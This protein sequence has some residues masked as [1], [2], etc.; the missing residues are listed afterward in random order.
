MVNPGICPFTHY[1]LD[2]SFG[3]SVCLWRVG[4]GSN[5][6]KTKALTGSLE[7]EGFVAGSVV[8]HDALD[9]DA[10]ALVIGD[11]G[12]EESDGAAAGLVGLDLGKGG[13]RMVV[14][15]DMHMVPADAAILCLPDTMA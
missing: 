4:P 15:G 5:V 13:A 1:G 12:F 14:Y 9:L 8:G 3:F 10:K 7:G 11:S 2:E 6:F